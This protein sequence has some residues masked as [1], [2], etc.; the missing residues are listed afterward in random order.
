MLQVKGE[1][2]NEIYVL[3]TGKCFGAINGLL[4]KK[5]EGKNS[6]ITCIINLN[7]VDTKND[8]HLV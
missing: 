7:W 2:H 1:G 4:K 6:G 5:I 3:C 8:T